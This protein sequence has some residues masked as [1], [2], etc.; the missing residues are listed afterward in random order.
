MLSAWFGKNWGSPMCDPAMHCP[1]PV[2]EPCLW[3]EER[4]AADDDGFLSAVIDSPGAALQLREAPYHL[5]CY[6]RNVVGGVNHLRGNCKC[7]GGT[8]PPD[9]PDLTKRQAAT[10]AAALFH[11]ITPLQ[12]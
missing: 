6:I 9:P 5:D 11:K 12:L 10:E 2:G 3:C 7:C 8:E 4:I 1:T